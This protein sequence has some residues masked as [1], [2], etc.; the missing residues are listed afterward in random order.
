MRSFIHV[1]DVNLGFQPAQTALWTVEPGEKYRTDAEKLALYQ[2]L[3]RRVT[4]IP[5]VTSAG[6]TDCLP[7]GRNRG[8]WLRAKGVQYTPGQEPLGYPRMVDAGYIPTMRIPLRD[9]RT[10]T[11]RDTARS[12]KVV[13][14]NENAAKRLWPG[15]SAVGQIALAGNGEVRVIGVVANVRHSSLEEDA[16]LEMYFPITQM[17][18]NSVEMVV[19]TSRP[20]ESIAP[21]VRIAMRGV[22]PSLPTAEF[23]TLGDVV[24]RSVSPRRFV[25]VLLGGFAALALVLA[26]LGIYGVVSY[27]VTQRTQEIGIRMALGASAGQVQM[28]VLRQTVVLALIGAGIGVVVSMAAARLMESLLYGVQPGDIATFAGMLG[29]LTLVAALAGY[30]PAR[31]ASRIDPMSA[32]RSE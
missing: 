32:L 26:S 2:E 10:F 21:E 13:V 25:V 11:E 5:G 17:T 16:G 9:G 28:R 20:A 22:E 18:M 8:W 1:L 14:L 12:E 30:L 3:V 31:R 29:V 23:R 19:R 24:D 27:S 4:A 15:R 7:L 6:V